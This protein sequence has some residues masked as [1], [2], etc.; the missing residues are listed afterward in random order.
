MIEQ[1]ELAPFAGTLIPLADVKAHLRVDQTF[2]D[3]IIAGYVNAAAAHIG[4][5]LCWR[6]LGIT[7]WR[8]TYDNWDGQELWLL[9]PPIVAVSAITVV[10]ESDVPFDVV[11]IN[12]D[13]YVLDKG[14]GRVRF[15]GDGV[16]GGGAAGRLTVAYTAGYATLPAWARQAILLL[17]GHYYENRESVVVGAGV[18]A[19]A[20]P[21]AVED[22]CL[23]HRAWRPGGAI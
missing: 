5:V 9:Y 22:L 14:L 2:D 1:E 17:T 19:M 11:T 3:A 23:A 21:Q 4:Q 16:N 7:G 15:Y 20:I 10:D 18:T 12:P 6:T 13:T 8:S